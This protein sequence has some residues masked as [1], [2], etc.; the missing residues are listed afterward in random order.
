[1]LLFLS[2]TRARLARQYEDALFKCEDE[3]YELDMVIENNG[4]AL[5]WLESVKARLDELPDHEARLRFR[6]TP[7]AHPMNVL[8]LRAIAR[9][10]GDH[11]NELVDLLK[12]SPY[13]TI[14]VIV[15]R[16]FQ[17]DNE[18]RK[19]RTDMK[20]AWRDVCE[21]NFNKSLD[22]RSFYFKQED[23]KKMAPKAL[24]AELRELHE[25]VA[26]NPF[27]NAPLVP[28][29]GAEPAA[30][31]AAASSASSS[32]TAVSVARPADVHAM[33]FR[34]PDDALHQ[35]V[36]AVQPPR[37]SAPWTV[38][39]P[40]VSPVFVVNVFRGTNRFAGVARHSGGRRRQILARRS[41]AAHRVLGRLCDSIL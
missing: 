18:W 14:P 26:A 32:S 22:H 1:M 24:V 8:H 30:F 7:A 36:C 19:V 13:I 40:R 17:K 5:R 12:V 4:S 15:G 28:L 37:P 23:R 31:A 21:K 35:E 16:L 6:L 34:M 29:A 41:A 33:R 9:V 25:R 11:A 3:R 39:R 10:Y 38:A 2:L 27:A 20:R